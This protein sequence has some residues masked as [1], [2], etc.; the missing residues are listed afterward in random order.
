MLKSKSE[1]VNAKSERIT[2]QFRPFLE[3][4]FVVKIERI[5]P[6]AVTK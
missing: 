2:A 4:I 1:N 3:E 6:R 5:E